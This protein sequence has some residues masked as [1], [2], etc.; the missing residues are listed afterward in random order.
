MA[1]PPGLGVIVRVR[2]SAPSTLRERE[3]ERVSDKVG[4]S[5]SAESE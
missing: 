1:I 3:R 5:E 4:D 2:V